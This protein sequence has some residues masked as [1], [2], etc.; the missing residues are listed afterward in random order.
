MSD[1]LGVGRKLIGEWREVN[2]D[3]GGLEAKGRSRRKGRGA[4]H[5]GEEGDGAAR[6]KR[7]PAGFTAPA[8]ASELLC[9]FMDKAAGTQMSRTDATRAVYDYIR[10]NKR[11]H[12]EKPNLIVPDERLAS[13]LH[14]EDGKENDGNLYLKKLQSYLKRHFPPSK[15]DLKAAEAVASGGSAAPAPAPEVA[16]AA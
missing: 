11:I 4:K 1:L 10:A 3:V 16:A 2:K 12:P 9:A 8:P 5:G 6:P 13:I 7:K 15:K 14:P